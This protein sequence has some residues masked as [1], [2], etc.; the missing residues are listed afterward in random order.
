LIK[1]LGVS[2]SAFCKKEIE[3]NL[4][5]KYKSGIENILESFLKNSNINYINNTRKIISPL[6]LDFYLPEFNLAIECNGLFTHSELSGR[7]DKRYHQNKTIKCISKNISL[8]HIFENEIYDHWDIICSR[9][10]SKINQNIKLMARK[11]SIKLLSNDERTIFFNRCHIQGD[12]KTSL[13]YG[14]VYN[15]KI[16]AAMSFGKSRFN[17]KFEWEILRYSSELNT[18]VVGGASKL[19]AHFI[20]THNPNSVITYADRRWGEGKFYE[21]LGFTFSHSSSPNYFYTKN[22]RSVYS[23]HEFQKH[24]LK[25]KLEVFDPNL[26]EW[27]NMSTNGWD[28]IWDCGNNVYY[29]YQQ[30]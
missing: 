19:F 21:N 11:C 9:I 5:E 18:N 24:K 1:F 22:H 14:L 20:K 6:E 2:H 4:R 27:Q 16:I 28:R 7:K 23:R 25:D 3:Y 29:W 12:I 26:T 15:D 8:I 30:T 13:C 17:K 10:S